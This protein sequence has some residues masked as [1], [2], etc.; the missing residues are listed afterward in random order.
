MNLQV[1]ES[2]QNSRFVSSDAKAITST[3][4]LT[5]A[6]RMYKIP[7]MFQFRH[8]NS[9][10]RSGPPNYMSRRVQ[11]RL[12]IL[13]SSL[14][15]V[16][17]LMAEVRKPKYWDWMWRGQQ[18]QTQSHQDMSN[19]NDR[20][21]VD[22]RLSTRISQN[23]ANVPDAVIIR[24]HQPLGGS[25]K[26]GNS[27]FPGVQADLLEVIEDDCLLRHPEN[28]AWCNLLE[29]LQESELKELERASEGRVGFVSLF[30]QPAFYRGR[31]VTFLGSARRVEQVPA[32]KNH[33]GIEDYFACWLRPAGGPNAPVN[34]YALELPEGFPI[35]NEIRESVEL[36]GFFFKR[37]P[38]SA[39]DGT[40]TTPLI[41]AKTVRW[42]PKVA[43]PK[44]TTSGPMG[45]KIPVA[46]TT[47]LLVGTV[48]LSASLAGLTYWLS[49]RRRPTHG[50][51]AGSSIH[52][53]QI[54]QLL[55]R[56]VVSTRNTLR[57][58]EDL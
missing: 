12:L 34:V 42:S 48:I 15:G 31:L 25:V 30:Q 19:Q 38:Y 18:F 4:G 44:Q 11:L 2:C 20:P 40:R 43:A 58:M 13:V 57:K 17:L 47:G 53:E 26:S 39:Q 3:V 54:E 32:W 9:S 37:V 49:V 22:T 23:D 28:A 51:R 21:P 27:Y 14:L 10:G 36:T 33:L 52:T 46:A 29:I 56:D 7:D 16:A 1:S 6:R 8:T 41:I 45:T 55:N 35:G 5:R 24:P 50:Y